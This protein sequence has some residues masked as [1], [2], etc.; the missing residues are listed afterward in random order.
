M[1]GYMNEKQKEY[2]LRNWDKYNLGLKNKNEMI[3]LLNILE[4]HG[5]TLDDLHNANYEFCDI[6]NLGHTWET[7]ADIVESLFDFN[8]FLTE[9][10][11]IDFML[12]RIEETKADYLADDFTLDDVS[13]FFKDEA[14]DKSDCEIQKTSD[15]YVYIIHC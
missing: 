5:E 8:S 11:F 1:S 4:A 3:K 2:I 10:E 14:F 9:T 7:D 13:D 12:T 6:V 15:G